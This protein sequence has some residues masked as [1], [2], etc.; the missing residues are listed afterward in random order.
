MNAALLFVALS[1]VGIDHGWQP[2]PDGGVEY[3]LQIEPQMLETLRSQNDVESYLPP[4]LDVK[5]IRVTVGNA[6][7]PKDSG[8]DTAGDA[9]KP[10]EENPLNATDSSTE[11]PGAFD[12]AAELAS[13]SEIPEEQPFARRQDRV[14]NRSSDG[15]TEQENGAGDAALD[16]G[17]DNPLKSNAAARERSKRQ[18]EAGEPQDWEA[19]KQP[20][21]NENAAPGDEKPSAKKTA[22]ADKPWLPLT[23]TA[24][25]LCLSLAA[26]FY[27]AWIARDARQ[28]YRDL[29]D[30]VQ[31]PTATAA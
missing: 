18:N 30:Q 28:R 27:L 2:L 29:L 8:S 31:S 5:K 10:R 1:A 4:G 22:E 11:E 24:L 20:L 9:S 14:N 12:A 15:Q 3:I 19:N 26:N 23:V 13:A 6:K 17:S 21:W 16:S 7:L 25:A